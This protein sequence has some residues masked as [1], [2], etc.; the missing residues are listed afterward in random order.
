[1]SCET[2]QK[3]WEKH[4]LIFTPNGRMEW[5]HRYAW[6]PVADHT[7]NDLYKIF[8]AARNQDNLSQVGYITLN[9]NE[10]KNILEVSERPVLT[11]GPLGAFDDSAVIPSCI[12]CAGDKKYLYYVGWMQGRRVPYYASVGLA[13]S[14]DGGKNYYKFSQG[15]LLERN[16]IDPYFTASLDILVENGVWR[17]WYSSN[18]QWTIV[19]GQPTP[20]YHIKYAESCDGIHWQ[21]EGK[22]AIDFKSGDEYA[23][24]R[25]CV[26]KENGIY[27]MWYSYRGEAYRIGYA[28]SKDGLRWERKDEETGIDVSRNGWDSK[29]VEYAFVFNH[30]GR[31]HMFYNGNEYGEDG[32]GY[33]VSS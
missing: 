6:V 30:G 21:R 8:F 12:V 31:K 17:M 7:K 18:T 23:I 4:G 10:P 11:L 5:M 9:L 1:M 20:R 33:A 24:A 32:I 22:V 26:I 2:A 25:P 13:I 14:E 15:P 28:E 27:K 29:S 19:E 3:K 16:D